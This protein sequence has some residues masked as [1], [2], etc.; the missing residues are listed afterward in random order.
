MYTRPILKKI[1]ANLQKPRCF[2]Q[3]LAGPRQVGKTTLTHQIEKIIDFPSIYVSADGVGSGDS[4][5]I[6]QQWEIGRLEA[7]TQS[8][9]NGALLIIDEIQKITQWSETVKM[10][11]DEDTASGIPL[12][13]MLLGS[14]TLLLQKGLTE[15]LARRFEVTPM[16]HWSFEECRDA[17]GWNA[18]QFI[19]F[20]GYPGAAVLIEEQDR[21]A[22]YI[23]DSLIETT[24][25]KDILHMVTIHKPILLRR[26]F[27][28]GCHYSGQILSYQKML[29]Q[30]LEAG[31]AST[32]ANYLKILSGAGLITGLEK[33]SPEKV[34]QKASSP[35]LQVLNTALMSSQRALSFEKTRQDGE[36]WGHLV[37]SA[38]GAHLIN[39]TVGSLIETFYWREG[40]EEVDFVLRKGNDILPIE[41][42]STARRTH[43]PG[44]AGFAKRFGSKRALLV[45]SQG[46]SVEKFLLMNPDDLF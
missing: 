31:N 17:F 23:R 15:S 16:M 22:R 10:L 32:L 40:N 39:T 6:Q 13:I 9:A 5:W 4:H 8:S 34:R 44:I 30:L 20:G 28:L 43:L 1:L 25:S 2:I 36:I 38:I 7:K 29:G 41:V 35:K 18:D 42:K 11:W 26:L 27:E 45:G 14:S 33:F 37:E 12:K 19:Y 3:V 46:L 21:W 24:V